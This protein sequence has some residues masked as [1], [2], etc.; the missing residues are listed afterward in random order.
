MKNKVLVRLP[1]SYKRGP[2][3][4]MEITSEIISEAGLD[5]VPEKPLKL[6]EKVLRNLYLKKKLSQSKISKL[7]QVQ[8]S[9]ARRWLKRLKIP[10]KDKGDAVS[11]AL[12]KYKKTSFSGNKEEKAY[13]MGLSIGDLY[14]RRHGRAIRVSL[15]TTK[16]EMAGVFRSLFKKYGRVNEYPKYNRSE[17]K[18][19]WRLYSDLDDSFKFLLNQ[20]ASVPHQILQSKKRFFQFISGYFDAEGCLGIYPGK[21]NNLQWIICS[22]DKEILGA[23]KD[24]LRAEEF[25]IKMNNMTNHGTSYKYN[26]KYWRIYISANPEVIKILEKMNFKHEEK[27]QKA[28]LSRDLFSNNWKNAQDKIKNLKE[29]FKDRKKD[30]VSK[31]KKEYL[32]SH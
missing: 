18:Y 11:E 2:R 23:I 30:F 17:E 1:R 9:T 7:F 5:K 25:N 8:R 24:F 22:Y 14:V 29:K 21:Y 28:N 31:A 10:I 32:K 6:A 15:A 13:L 20:T 3:P 19:L 27:K 26:K 12:S 16:P 4:K